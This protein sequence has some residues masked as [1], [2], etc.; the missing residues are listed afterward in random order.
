MK[1]MIALIAVATVALTACTGP[2][3]LSKKFHTWQINCSPNEWIQEV[4]FLGCCIIPVYPICLFV[5]AIVFNSIEFWSGSNPIA[6]QLNANGS[7]RVADATG[8][9]YDLKKTQEGIN[10]IDMQ[11]QFMFNMQRSGNEVV[12]RDAQGAVVQ[13]VALQAI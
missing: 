8:K 7:V 11:G 9:V 4:A 1:K 13:T 6:T 2:F 3:A 5:D 10:A 12:Y